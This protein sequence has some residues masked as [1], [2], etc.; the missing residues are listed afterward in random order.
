MVFCRNKSVTLIELIIAIVLVAVIILGISSINIFSNYHIISS[1]RRAKVQNEVSL[2]LEHITKEAS[3]AIGNEA[4]FIGNTVV[5]IVTNT[6]LAVFIDADLDGKRDTAK[7]YWIKYTFANNILSYC[8]NCGNSFVCGS[9]SISTEVL[10]KKITAFN[11][12]KDF[13]DGNH[14]EVSITGC[15][16]PGGTPA[17]GTPDNPEITMHTAVDLPSVSTR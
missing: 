9:C 11:P 6:S 5:D 16:N 10:S 13:A 14:I 2:C 8:G 7:D 1:D 4:V 12:K 17:C 15:H 3:R